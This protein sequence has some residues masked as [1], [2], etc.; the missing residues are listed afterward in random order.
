MPKLAKIS[1]F[2]KKFKARQLFEK[3]ETSV[4]TR[5]VTKS[6][7]ASFKY[8]SINPSFDNVLEIV[9]I[10]ALGIVN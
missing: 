1:N 8:F 5:F 2:T 10:N 6:L 4:V 7:Q 9:N 3:F